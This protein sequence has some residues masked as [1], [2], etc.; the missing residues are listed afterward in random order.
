L[1]RVLLIAFAAFVLWRITVVGV[2][3]IYI[4]QHQRGDDSA[5]GKALAW[6]PSHP[7]AAYQLAAGMSADNAAEATTVERLRHA[8]GLNPTDARPLLALARLA[9][10]QGNSEQAG[11][12][13]AEA[14][15]L[16][17]ADPSI[18]RQA[19]AFWV[20]QG[21]LENAM[22]HWSQALEA[23]PSARGTIFPIL[24]E[25]AE[26]PELRGLLVPYLQTPPA[27]WEGFF[28]EVARRALDVGTVRSLNSLRRVPG[29]TPLTAEER[30]VYI[31]RLQRDG[32]VT[33]AYLVWLN[34]LS[35]EE[36]AHLGLLHNGG[37]ELPPTNTGFDWHLGKIDGVII[38]TATTYGLQG[39]KALHL[40]FKRWEKPFRHVHQPLFLDPGVYLIS[41]RVRADSLQ[42]NGGLKWAV[43]CQ[44]PSAGTLAESERFLGSSEWRDFSFEVAIPESCVAQELRL[45]SAGQREFEH[46]MVGSIWFDAISLRRIAAPPQ[47]VATQESSQQSEAI[48]TDQSTP[49]EAAQAAEESAGIPAPATPSTG[50]TSASADALPPPP[51]ENEGQEDN[52]TSGQRQQ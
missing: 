52:T 27:W 35:E 25:I 40:I 45:L 20:S 12:L 41:G 6:N 26:N 51:A 44:L 19:A 28:A 31:A 42:S 1:R 38:Q 17:P 24:L 43:R 3:N 15:K 48:P 32:L 29:S 22:R 33:E 36:R 21:N 7:E 11:A 9:A 13:A 23:D 18:Q 30:K 50:L 2:S 37:F 39:A 8:Y 47:P 14:A 4:A 49:P 46:R 10:S 34:G 5:A 16:R